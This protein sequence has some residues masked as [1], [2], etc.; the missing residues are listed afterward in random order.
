MLTCQNV[1]LTIS[2]KERRGYKCPS[3]FLSYFC[4]RVKNSPGCRKTAE[5]PLM[6]GI[7]L[8]QAKSVRAQ[9]DL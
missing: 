6:L 4:Y 1:E 9:R 3:P 7:T 8:L 2:G 5:V